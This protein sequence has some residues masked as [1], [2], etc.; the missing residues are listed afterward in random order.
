MKI[1]DCFTFFNELDLLEIRLNELNDIVDYFVIVE[2][3][4][5]FQSNPKPMYFLDN[6]KRYEKFLDKIIHVRIPSE[7]LSHT[8]P[9]DNEKLSFDSC[10]KGL[11]NANDNDIVMISTVDEIPSLESVKKSIETERDCVV[12]HQFFYFYLNTK[13]WLYEPNRTT[14]AG[15]CITKYNNIKDKGIKDWFF[16]TREHGYKIYGCCHFSFLGDDKNTFTKVNSYSHNEYNHIS[17]DFYQKNLE[18]LRDPFNRNITGFHSFEDINNLP[19]FVR[20]NINK[21]EK[22]FKV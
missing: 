20:E 12:I 18:E 10:S 7:E 17:E 13:F 8:N 14:W 16:S 11:I 15:S 19:K 3:E 2:G 21:L 5:T 9:W 6:K 22:Y 4:N 1:Y